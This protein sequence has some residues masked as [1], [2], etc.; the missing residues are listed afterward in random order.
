M[1]SNTYVQKV[2]DLN[3]SI[4]DRYEFHKR[5][6]E[7]IV[8]MGKDKTFWFDLFKQNL[9]DKGYLQRKWTMY[10]IPFFYVYENDDFYIKVHLFVPLKTYEPHV[11]ASAI[12]HHNN[13]LLTSYA[14]YGSGYEALIFEKDFNTD[15]N[16]KKTDL[17]VREHFTQAE[18]PMHMVDAWEPHAVVNPI[19]LSATLVLW[20]PD[21]KRATDALRSNPLLK[22]IKVP[23]RKLIYILG[24]DKKIGIAAKDTYQYFVKENNFYGIPEDDF[25][26]PTRAQAGPEVDD[27]S[28]QTVFA[29]MQRMGFDD[30]EFL[31]SMLASK[32]VPT[33][34][35]KWI[36]M[37]LNN[38][39]I[40]DTFAKEIINVP[41]GRMM[42]ND[43]LRAANYEPNRK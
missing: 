43:V 38:E 28:I 17:R 20:S 34:Y 24:L 26:A 10:E 41:G 8:Q 29:F 16:T 9:S 22:M 35:Q 36:K 13:Y 23:L 32:D 3:S 31:K 1:H 39:T 27:Y 12:H 25:F 30:K 4:Q 18:R 42:V 37:L 40:K 2:I 15:P 14:A 33:Y 6:S 7:F 5:A 11:V 19:S 21:K